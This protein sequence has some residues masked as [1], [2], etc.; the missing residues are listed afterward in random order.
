MK[1]LHRAK[2]IS[3]YNGARITLKE[4]M[5]YP[6]YMLLKEAARGIMS[7]M[8]EDS[9]DKEISDKT[10]LTRLLEMMN[11]DLMTDEQVESVKVL[12]DAEESGLSGVLSMDIDELNDIRKSIKK[13]I[14]EY[15]KEP[16]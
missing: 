6:A 14:I 9:L 15:F 2:A 11:V 8:V 5:S 13:L 3:A 4:N 1:S 16:I 12:I 10:K 7:Y